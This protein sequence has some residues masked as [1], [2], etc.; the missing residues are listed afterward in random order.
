ML[1]HVIL[2][3]AASRAKLIWFIIQA[4]HPTVF[5]ITMLVNNIQD[6]QTNGEIRHFGNETDAISFSFSALSLCF[7]AKLLTPCID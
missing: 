1:L 4:P 3:S 5:G 2:S 6:Q 7:S